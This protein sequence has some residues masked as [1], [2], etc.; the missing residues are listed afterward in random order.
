MRKILFIIGLAGILFYLF[1]YQAA[2]ASV[3]KWIR[4]GRYQTKVVDSGDQSESAGEGTFGYYYFDGFTGALFDHAG[5]Q[6]AVKNWV[7]P[8]GKV[9]PVKISGAP[10]GNSDEIVNTMPIPDKNGIYIHRYFRYPPPKITVDGVR[11][12]PPFPMPGDE[13]APDK[14]PGTADVMVESW[15]NTSMGIT[16]HQR[17]LGWSQKNHDD[18]IVYDWTFKNTGNINTDPKIELPNQTLHDVYFERANN[19]EP[20]GNNWIVPWYSSYG[21]YPTDSL[22]M[23]FAYPQRSRGSNFDNFGDPD[24]STG[25]LTAPYEIGEAMLHVDKS[26]TDHSDN[27]AQPEMTGVETAELPWIKLHAELNG[28][29]QWALVYQTLSLGFK[30]Y[31]GTPEMQGTWPGHH[32]I[33]MDERGVKFVRDFP[34]WNWRA[35]TYTASGPFTLA[36]GDSF[37]IVWATVMGS[38]TPQEAWKIG[39][40]WKDGSCS[41]NGP[42]DLGKYY[43]AF[44]KYPDL[45]PTK[46]DQAK[47]RW[48]LTGRDSIF[49]NAWAAQWNVRHNYMVPIPPPPPS[50]T[51][52]SLPNEIKISWDTES[53]TVSNFAGYKVYRATGAPDYSEEGGV[54]VGKWEKIFECGKGTSNP[55]AHSYDDKTAQRGISYFYYVTAF[56]DGTH[57]ETSYP[58]GVKGVPE[59]LESGEFL[60]RTTVGAHLTRPYGNLST[61]RVVPNPFN[62]GAKNLQ[63]PGEPDKIMFMGLPPV[64]TIKIFSENGDLIKVLKHTDGSGDEPWGR[65]LEAQSTTQTGQVIVSGLYIAHI[66]TPSGKSTNVKFLVVR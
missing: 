34:W 22:R 42:D 15:I 62:I 44:K 19:F 38:M 20:N 58:G 1:T 4:V 13:V 17:V 27:P 8:S 47:D 24:E 5:W 45:A 16:I 11:L 53:E 41:W 36:P 40:E 18:Y 2:H 35:C 61:V 14:I 39:K 32:S 26:V 52:K 63:F 60:N 65:V 66:E 9:W 33:R 21:E 30:P 50:I 7:D 54:V 25:F 3:I 29:S 57:P 49:A 10:H 64:C 48:V 23:V 55:L 56:D 43:P 46:N 37:R 51:V 28:P 6:L 31:D 59:S 12:D